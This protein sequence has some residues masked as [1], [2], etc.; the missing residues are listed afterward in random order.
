MIE[1]L[2]IFSTIAL[3]CG[4]AVIGLQLL[5]GNMLY[6]VFKQDES[7][8]CEKQQQ[9]QTAHNIARLAA[10]VS[11]AFFAAAI[12]LLFFEIGR[13]LGVFL[14]AQIFSVACDVS[15][16]AFLVL[17]VRLYIKLG[18]TK[19]QKAKFS[20]SNVHVTLYVLAHVVLL[21]VLSLLY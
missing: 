4:S 7:A 3:A 1:F 8:R 21:T 6:L 15:M 14:V 11:F 9:E 20:S 16:L 13:S 12:S 18:A 19:D 17:I 2:R 5:R 10:P